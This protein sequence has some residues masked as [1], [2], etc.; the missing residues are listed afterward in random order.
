MQHI[1]EVGGS[2]GVTIGAVTAAT[3][4]AAT[5]YIA[6]RPEPLIPPLDLSDQAT[7]LEVM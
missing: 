4:V 7:V 2:I 5:Y 3:A 1:R 6:T